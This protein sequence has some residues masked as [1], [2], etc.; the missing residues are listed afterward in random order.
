LSK[1][2]PATAERTFTIISSDYVFMVFL[3]RVVREL[4]K[5]APG[6]KLRVILT[7]EQTQEQL[8]Q[9][10]V[11]FVIVP[12]QRMVPEH[13]MAS[14]FED[15]F[16]CIAW[17]GNDA[18]SDEITLE[19]YLQMEH[20]STSLGPINTPHIEQETLEGLGVSRKIA[21]YA[22]NFTLA[23]DAI[24]ET[25]YIATLHSR[26]AKLLA[27]RLPIKVLAPPLVIP[28]FSEVVQWHKNRSADT[29]SI[30]LRNFLVECGRNLSG[31]PHATSASSG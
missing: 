5:T 17:A 21:L 30:W 25:P 12:E 14:L 10:Q 4:S 20:V 31:G 29:G 11:D 16:S 18:I 24:L 19:Q 28:A 13:P 1:F 22:P 7:S 2:D 9:G 26:A 27:E 23:A 15:D 3:T 6:I 8:R